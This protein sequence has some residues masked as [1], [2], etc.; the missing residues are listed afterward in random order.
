MGNIYEHLAA[1]TER[2]RRGEDLKPVIVVSE[3]KDKWDFEA[4]VRGELIY[5]HG[6]S[7]QH[8]LNELLERLALLGRP[9]RQSDYA[10]IHRR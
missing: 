7:R 8:A 3:R 10:I 5:A 1:D 6:T 4:R 2:D 9:S